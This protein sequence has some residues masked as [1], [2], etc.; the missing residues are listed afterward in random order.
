MEFAQLQVENEDFFNENMEHLARVH[1]DSMVGNPDSED[2]VQDDEKDYELSFIDPR[3]KQS[4]NN[5][6]DITNGL[7]SS[8]K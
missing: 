5:I 4:S 3:T 1:K 6:E 2:Q 7:G 8:Q